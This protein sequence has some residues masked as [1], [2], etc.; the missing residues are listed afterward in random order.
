MIV[1]WNIDPQSFA[2]GLALGFLTGLY[3]RDTLR[4]LT[5]SIRRWGK[6]GTAH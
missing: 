1:M 5:V 3:L 2:I 6:R 4:W